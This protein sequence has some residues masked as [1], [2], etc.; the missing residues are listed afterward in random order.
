[1]PVA[2][3]CKA[4]FQ[5][6]ISQLTFM[7]ALNVRSAGKSACLI[8]GLLVLS[9]LPENAQCSHGQGVI[10]SES[11]CVRTRLPGEG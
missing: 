5:N 11:A 1:M 9:T 7:S 2:M 10:Q 4:F 8:L 3:Q 6:V